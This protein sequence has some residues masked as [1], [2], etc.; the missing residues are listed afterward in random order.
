KDR[1][2]LF[3]NPQFTYSFGVT[4]GSGDVRLTEV[5]RAPDIVEA[6]E[7]VLLTGVGLRKE[8]EVGH[9]TESTSR[10]FALSVAPLNKKHNQEVYGVVGIFHEITE[11][12]KAER[13]RIEFVGNVSHELRTPLT[14]ISGYLQTLDADVEKGHLQ[15]AKKF[16]KI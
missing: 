9:P 7:N 13:I 8:V 14:A 12:K 1:R 10:Y 5:L 2:I 16:L 11:L 4:P 6:Y 3:Y 15:Q